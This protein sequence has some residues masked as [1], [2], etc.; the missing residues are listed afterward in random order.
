MMEENWIFHFFAHRK[1][2]LPKPWNKTFVILITE[3]TSKSMVDQ[4]QLYFDHH[5]MLEEE[6]HMYYCGQWIVILQY[7]NTDYCIDK[8]NLITR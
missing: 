3:N 8:F 1:I 5:R 2:E 6:V 4:H 7:R